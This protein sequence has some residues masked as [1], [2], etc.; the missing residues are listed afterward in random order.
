MQDQIAAHICLCMV[1]SCH[2]FGR[3][4]T[5]YIYM[6]VCVCVCNLNS[7]FIC[8]V[9]MHMCNIHVVYIKIYVLLFNKML[10]VMS[11]YSFV[12]VRRRGKQNRGR[13]L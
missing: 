2:G 10:T 9:Y 8:V 7:T 3:T 11:T 4:D 6:C 13:Y 12:G 1:N 5:D